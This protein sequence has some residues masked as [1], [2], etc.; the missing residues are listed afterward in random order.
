MSGIFASW[1]DQ[2]KTTL[3]VNRDGVL[4]FVPNDPENSDFAWLIESGIEIIDFVAPAAE[5][6]QTVTPLQM[7]R[8]L[9]Q[10]GF[11]DAVQQWAASAGPD[12]QDAWE[13][14]VAFERSNSS[15]VAAAAALGKTPAQIDDLFRLAASL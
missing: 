4:S 8:A 7:R 10:V 12:A 2:H 13:Y 15:I 11:M 5:V 9:R 14:A 3:L 1:T 6:P